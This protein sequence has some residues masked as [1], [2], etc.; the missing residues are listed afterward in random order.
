MRIKPAGTRVLLELDDKPH[1]FAGGLEIA[2]VPDSMDEYPLFPQR[3]TVIAA[4]DHVS[5]LEVGDYVVC[6]KH[7]GVRLPKAKWGNRDLMLIKE[8][9]VLL[10]IVDPEKEVQYGDSHS[11]IWRYEGRSRQR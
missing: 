5:D 9:F 7:N 6:T 4:G 1:T 8:E 11:E 2:R 3:G 10:V